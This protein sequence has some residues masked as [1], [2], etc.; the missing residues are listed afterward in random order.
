MKGGKII[1]SVV[2]A[3]AI[4]AVLVFG[5]MLFLNVV[6]MHGKELV[7]PDFSSLT[8]AQAKELA[9]DAKVRI[10]VVDSVYVRKMEKGVV[11][12]QNPEAGSMVKKGRRI[13]ITINAHSSR[14]VPVPNLVG[15]SMRQATAE[16]QARGLALGR[17]IYKSDMATNNV[18]G[19]E[20]GGVPVVPG[21][22]YESGTAI[23]LVVGLNS[24]DYSTNV[25]NII[26]MKMI[27]A[28]DAI[29]SNSLNIG[30]IQCDSTIRTYQDSIK[31]VVYKQSP[32]AKYRVKKG[33]SVSM[34]LT[35]EPEKYIKKPAPKKKS[36]KK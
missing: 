6:T 20:R 13:L 17:L 8:V 7:V 29:H 2:I 25:P 22:K 30:T 32:P 15:Y 31:A 5:S 21:T 19:Q 26:G 11:Y 28:V 1:I 33:H 18:L 4:V 23:D 10:D 36:K 3:A 9:D 34:A 14:K 27:S 16:L 12:K 35:L 24:S